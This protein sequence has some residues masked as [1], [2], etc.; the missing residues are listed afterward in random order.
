MTVEIPGRCIVG[1]CDPVSG[2]RTTL[3][4]VRVVNQGPDTSY[5]GMC[6]PTPSFGEQRLIDGKW[7]FTGPAVACVDGPLTMP[8]A[9]G[10]SLLA[11]WFPPKGT[12]RITLG[13]GP[14]PA[15]QDL[16]LDASNAVRLR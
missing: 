5:V 15:P 12:S 9:P 2:D 1:G 7:E 10:D 14:T 6:G 4:L 3:A 16:E 8:L 11:N 13:V